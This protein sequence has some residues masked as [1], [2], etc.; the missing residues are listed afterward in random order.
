MIGR[1]NIFPTKSYRV[2]KLQCILEL[3]NLCNYLLNVLRLN[4]FRVL[5]GDIY[6][7]R[8]FKVG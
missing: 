5:I 3:A 7:L 4:L 6:L 2:F 8:L 1:R